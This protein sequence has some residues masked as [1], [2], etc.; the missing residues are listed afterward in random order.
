[1]TASPSA[2]G[3]FR[4]RRPTR[5]A[6]GH[7]IVTVLGTGTVALM[8]R[9]GGLLRWMYPDQHLS[10]AVADNRE[11]TASANAAEYFLILLAFPIIGLMLGALGSSWGSGDPGSLPG[12]GCPLSLE[13]TPDPPAGGRPPCS[14]EHDSVNVDLQVP[15]CSIGVHL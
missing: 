12:G 7:G 14:P 3:R 10:A 1:M 15:G 2:D 5:P 8:P 9:S 6:A 13:P 11:L 4:N